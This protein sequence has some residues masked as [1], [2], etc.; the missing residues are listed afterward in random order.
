VCDASA[1]HMR[2]CTLASYAR[3]VLIKEKEK[4]KDLKTHYI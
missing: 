1:P 4:N 2:T 3:S